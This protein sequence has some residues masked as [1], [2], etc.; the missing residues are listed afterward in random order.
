[1]TEQQAK[2]ARLPPEMLAALLHTVRRRQ[3]QGDP[4]GARVV[5]RAL[6]TQQ[7]DDP[8]IWLALATVATTRD[9][10]RRAIEQVIAL[11]P[12][13]TL[14]LRALERFDT[15]DVAQTSATLEARATDE[16]AL[17]PPAAG[18][19]EAPAI[20]PAP[21]LTPVPEAERVR[22]IRWPLYAVI[23]VAVVLVLIAAA[24][25]RV[26][27]SPAA[28]AP[29][30]A[31]PGTGLPP[32]APVAT[33]APLP[34]TAVGAAPAAAVTPNRGPGLIPSAVR[35][36][37]T[38][39]PSPPPPST[40]PPPTLAPGAIV[41]RKPWHA[42]LLRPEHAVLL[43]GAIGSLQ[44]RGRF[45]LALIAVGN[46]GATPARIPANLFILEDRQGN[47]YPPTPAAST[48]YLNAY[49]RGQHGD[50]TLEEDLPPGGGNV[51]VPLI[52]DVPPGTRTFTLHMGDEP[53]GW[54]I[55]GTG[56]R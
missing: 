53:L 42:S 28:Q 3:Q 34:T 32:T 21:V 24:V 31:L 44:P 13:N 39:R 26:G 37:N 56:T 10:Q 15:S 7:P 40:T 25:L 2:Q 12:Q 19:N 23:G 6:V 1:M 36:T 20:T 18:T 38:A 14:A 35:P 54:A 43:D 22:A 41:V 29:T 49:G 16:T 52:F 46:D 9:E 17:A 55:G 33:A 4:I 11:D 5:L 47:R 48:A 51:S 50:L 30:P 8:R 27:P 45:V